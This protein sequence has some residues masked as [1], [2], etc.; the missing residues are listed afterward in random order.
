MTLTFE[1]ISYKKL[2]KGKRYLIKIKPHIKGYWSQYIGIFDKIENK[3]VVF[4]RV[5]TNMSIRPR[6]NINI[7]EPYNYFN[8]E[9]KK[10]QIQAAME[11]RAINNVLK[12]LI[13][14][15]FVY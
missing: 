13:D 10:E 14:D 9:F 15:S 3:E 12:R 2:I 8:V 7:K 11:L 5:K 1:K 4:L 6:I